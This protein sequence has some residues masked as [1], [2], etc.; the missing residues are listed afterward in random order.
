VL[1]QRGAEAVLAPL[2]P[3]IEGTVSDVRVR[4]KY[5]GFVVEAWPVRENPI[6]E[7]PAWQAG[8]STPPGPVVNILVVKL[9]GVSGGH[10]W[11]CRSCPT[12]STGFVPLFSRVFFR[13]VRTKFEFEHPK[14]EWLS[15]KLSVPPADE[16]VKERLRAAG[17]FEE[18]TWL[19]WGRHPY[20]PKVTFNPRAQAAGLASLASRMKE[21]LRAE[22][23]PELE[24]AIDEGMRTSIDE[25]P[26]E[27]S[28]QVE[29]GK[30]KAPTGDGFRELLDRA[31]RIAQINAEAN[32][33][34]QAGA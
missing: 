33:T 27:L 8:S 13:L 12:L 2:A 20:L 34:V 26:A 9:G 21:G 10:F 18:L 4:G 15:K 3:V 23:R 6:P 25:H 30:A 11:D 24:S 16:E 22:G 17:L 19:R 29:M 5:E 28:L 1:K 7:M 14:G 32:P 31:V